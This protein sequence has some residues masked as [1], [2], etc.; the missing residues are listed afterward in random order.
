MRKAC[1]FN[2]SK[3]EEEFNEKYVNEREG[4]SPRYQG[5]WNNYGAGIEDIK[6]YPDT[7]SHRQLYPEL[8]NFNFFG[9]ECNIERGGIGHTWCGYVKIYKTHPYFEIQDKIIEGKNIDC[10]EKQR[11]IGDVLVHGGITFDS[12]DTIGFDTH[13]G[14]DGEPLR[15]FNANKPY[16]DYKYVVEQVEFLALQLYLMLPKWSKQTHFQ[17]PLYLQE[18]FLRLYNLF[19]D[20]RDKI[21]EKNLWLQIISESFEKEKYQLF[22][23]HKDFIL[24]FVKKFN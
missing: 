23:N 8:Y 2:M 15:H 6:N 24:K 1:K 5:K 9:F 7:K 16:R 18:R 10:Y 22:C 21:Q 17:F 4:G 19:Y 3:M 20:M 13:H 12:E 11:V 14:W